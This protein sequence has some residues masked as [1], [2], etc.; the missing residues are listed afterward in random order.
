MTLRVNNII[1]ITRGGILY[2][3]HQKIV[4]WIDFKTCNENWITLYRGDPNDD[5][6]VGQRNTGKEKVLDVEFFTLPTTRFVFRSFLE[7]DM[8][9]LNPMKR[10]GGWSTQDLSVIYMQ[11]PEPTQEQ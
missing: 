8:R 6:C 1:T 4:H 9:L 5:H 10:H 11:Q 3:D 2:R 7:R